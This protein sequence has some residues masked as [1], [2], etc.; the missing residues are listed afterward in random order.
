[1]QWHCIIQASVDPD[2]YEKYFK[3]QHLPLA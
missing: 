1:V 3:E 2:A